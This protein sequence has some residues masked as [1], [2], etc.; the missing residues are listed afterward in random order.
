ML[1]CVKCRGPITARGRHGLAGR[2]FQGDISEPTYN[3]ITAALLDMPE[4]WF[5]AQIQK[6]YYKLSTNHMDGHEGCELNIWAIYKTTG[7]G[8]DMQ[9]APLLLLNGARHINCLL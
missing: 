3:I 2:V 7:L 1:E 6:K 8:K 9:K 5:Y 4:V